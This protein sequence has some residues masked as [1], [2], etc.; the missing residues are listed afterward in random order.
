LHVTA[1]SAKEVITLAT[2]S[3]TSRLAGRDAGNGR[4]IPVE[5][6]RQ[7]RQTAVVERLPLPGHG[8]SGRENGKK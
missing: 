4:F 5:Q 7:Q 1:R 3:P 2:K 8:T 6:A